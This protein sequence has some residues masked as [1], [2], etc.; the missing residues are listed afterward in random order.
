VHFL[1]SRE[2][3]ARPRMLEDVRRVLVFVSVTIFVDAMLYGVITP[4]VPG[5]VAD[6]GLS[7]FRA[8]L[9]VGAFGGGVLLG[10]IPSGVVASRFGPKRAVVVG[11][12]LLAASSFAFALAGSPLS[13]GLTRFGQGL[14]STTTWAGALS[15][16]TVTAPRA[17]RGQVLGTVF[18]FAVLGAIL[19][20]T[21]GAV[22]EFA[23]IRASFF[24]VGVVALALAAAAAVSAPATPEGS[25]PGA[26]RS[27]LRDPSFVLGLW[28]NTLPALFFGALALLAPIALAARGWGTFAIGA[29]F[30]VT[31]VLE[32]A[33][34]PFLGRAAD[35]RGTTVL[36]RLS[37]G[38]GVATALGLA[39]TARTGAVVA[40]FVLA[41]I[42][43]SALFT[44]GMALVSDR[45]DRSGLTQG[46]AFGVMNGAW[47][48]GQVVGAPVAGAVAQVS[49]DA[50]SYVACS[51]LCLLTLA[52]MRTSG[53]RRGAP[54]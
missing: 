32:A 54:A 22:A 10:A 52:A 40:F 11:L 33:L 34:N 31:G 15:W 6:Y 26:V 35:R 46:L 16:A 41:Y 8:G 36:I 2:G 3:N 29:L 39:A 48:L 4:L 19:G 13:L 37:L 27:A 23:G 50:V 12:L 7:K 24:V 17:R 14:S 51:V 43:F 20:P 1:W 38:A 21:F 25:S 18:G 5:Y 9:I 47:A 49:G 53:I 28:L 45:A 42:A 30:L 44:P